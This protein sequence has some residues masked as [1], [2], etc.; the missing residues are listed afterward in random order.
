MARKVCHEDGVS[1][2]ENNQPNPTNMHRYNISVTEKQK[3]QKDLMKEKR[4]RQKVEQSLEDLR[5]RFVVSY[6]N[7]SI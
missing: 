4:L 7:P 5:H 3:L 1:E 6:L 2:H